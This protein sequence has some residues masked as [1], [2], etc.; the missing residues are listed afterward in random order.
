[1]TN[2]LMTIE[3]VVA[4]KGKK[5]IEVLS[6]IEKLQPLVDH[7][8][9]EA[10]SVQFDVTT[11]KGRKEV[12]TAANNV[13]QSRKPIV[14]AIDKHISDHQAVVTGLKEAKGYIENEFKLIKDEVLKPRTEWQAEQDRIENERKEGIQSRIDNLRAVGALTGDEDRDHIE[15]L[16]EALEAQDLS[17]GFDE[18][19]QEA[20]QVRQEI[21]KNLS[22]RIMQIVENEIQEKNRIE[23]AINKMKATVSDMFDAPR[24]TIQAAFEEVCNLTIDDSFGDR[25]EEAQRVKEQTQKKLSKLIEMADDD[26]EELPFTDA[27]MISEEDEAIFNDCVADKPDR[28]SHDA[29]A[30]NHD[31]DVLAHEICEYAEG[32]LTL[33][34]AHHIIKM[35]HNH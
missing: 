31:N 22:D 5:A 16:I 21:I 7:V 19:T 34:Q 23:S 8:R 30:E 28:V 14:E 12:G 18:F 20:M 9:T 25:K 11:S 26:E 27:H 29:P 13:V 17:T 1:M 33:E 4:L 3:N 35:V 15:S 32:V 6:S 24:A 10:L 2:E